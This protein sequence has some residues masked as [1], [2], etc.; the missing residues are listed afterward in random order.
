MGE[1]DAAIAH[2]AIERDA[3]VP[4]YAARAM[5]DFGDGFI[6]VLLPVY[7]AALG[8][9]AFE[10]GVVATAALLGSALM[11]L[12]VGVLGARI[13]ERARLIAAAGL[14]VATGLAFAASQA[15]AQDPRRSGAPPGLP[16]PQSRRKG[17]RAG[18]SAWRAR[19]LAAR[20]GRLRA[21]KSAPK[22]L[23]TAPQGAMVAPATPHAGSRRAAS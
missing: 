14:M 7:L 16:A 15:Y 8:L 19:D 9:G 6:A 23:E 3:V 12:G 4:L 10:I 22:P 11:T 13:D 18:A 21:C 1:A 5:R 17:A 2:A 20:R